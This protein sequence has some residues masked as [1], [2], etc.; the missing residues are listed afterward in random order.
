MM[1][2]NVLGVTFQL[3]DLVLNACTHFSAF[4]YSKRS[5]CWQCEW[6]TRCRGKWEWNEALD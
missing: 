5:Y 6:E 1:I 3:G 4:R 2:Y